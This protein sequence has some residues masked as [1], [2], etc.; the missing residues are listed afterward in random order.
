MAFTRGELDSL[1]VLAEVGL[2][3]I[4]ELQRE[5]IASPPAPRP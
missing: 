4:T 5:M 2:A 3:E 1:L